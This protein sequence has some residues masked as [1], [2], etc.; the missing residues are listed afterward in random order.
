VPYGRPG[1]VYGC[2]PHKVYKEDAATVLFPVYS[3]FISMAVT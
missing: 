2:E 3:L 1:L